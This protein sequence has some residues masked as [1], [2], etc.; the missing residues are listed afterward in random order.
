MSRDPE[1]RVHGRRYPAS[2]FVSILEQLTSKTKERPAILDELKA[3]V[4][5]AIRRDQEHDG[6]S[7][8]G[9]GDGG[10]RGKGDH[11]DPTLSA[12]AQGL[13]AAWDDKSS[14]WESDPVHVNAVKLCEHLIEAD[15]HLRAAHSAAVRLGAYGRRERESTLVECANPRC[16]TTMTG[17]GE[18]RPRRGR[19]DRCYRFLLKHDRDW[20]PTAREDE[21]A[22]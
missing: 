7:L 22:A 17:I 16:D 1:I 15:N 14:G 13:G 18:D 6:D 9:A 5:D 20:T 19:C 11:S 8:R 10:P 3:A 2:F 4:V 12:A 21:E